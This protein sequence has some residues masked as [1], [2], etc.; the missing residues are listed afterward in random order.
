MLFRRESRLWGPEEYQGV[1]DDGIEVFGT[2]LNLENKRRMQRKQVAKV[3]A[4]KQVLIRKDNTAWDE[5]QNTESS[6]C[7]KSRRRIRFC[8][9]NSTVAE[10]IH[11]LLSKVSV[12]GVKRKF[13]DLMDKTGN[14][15]TEGFSH[16]RK[17]GSF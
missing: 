12:G 16:G 3:T 15:W 13:H 17:S 8:G 4:E 5:S 1:I 11:S 10:L 2:G 9:R 6:T 14:V 7:L